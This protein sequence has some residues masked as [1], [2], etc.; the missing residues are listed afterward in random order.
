MC[1]IL[2]VLG[3]NEITDE[4]F[5]AA[6]DTMIARGPDDAGSFAEREVHLGFRR[7]S[8]IDLSAAGHQPMISADGRYVIVFNGEIYNFRALRSELEADGA[9]FR[10]ESDTEV[11]LEM[12][13]RQGA[14]TV[15]R[16]RGM[17]ALA[18][19]DRKE[20]DLFLAR[21]RMGIKPLYLWRFPGGVAFASE[22]RALRALPGGPSTINR[23][24]IREFLH[25]GSVPE[26]LTMFEG[27][28]PL[29]PATTLLWKAGVEKKEV[30]W[31]FPQGPPD[32]I[33]RG[34]AI[35]AV[36]ACLKEAV[37]LHCISD[38]PLGAF[39]SGGIDSSAIVSLMRE[40]G[41]EKISTF[42]MSFPQSELDEGP[43]AI[44]VAEELGTSHSNIS[45][46]EQLVKGELD[47]F[48]AAMDQP[49]C[50]GFNSYMVS[51]F[52]KQAGLTVSLSGIGGD[53]LFAGYP[54]FHRSERLV[55]ILSRLPGFLR[56]FASR[57]GSRFS[58]RL[59]KLE[60]LSIDRDPA[61]ATYRLLRGLFSPSQVDALLARPLLQIRNSKS[62]IRNRWRP[63]PLSSS[64]HN[65]DITETMMQLESRRY[66][67][68]QLLRDTD[69]FGMAHSLE[70]RPPFLDHELVEIMFRIDPERILE[71]SQ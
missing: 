65:G 69:V 25:W 46:T 29:G 17:F 67:L 66:M 48:F 22:I 31:D 54:T 58:Q 21:D 32:I 64:D 12:Y 14:A 7:L 13:A 1:G 59:R 3:R 8:I 2:G 55:P 43:Y 30:Y 28:E 52:A 47:D 70:I 35:D 63:L 4:Q 26:P 49:T 44:R 62:E 23:Q 27:V 41:Q 11:I 24:A 45:V 6:R 42:S 51:K 38:A 68:N 39:L 20:E 10:S 18:I 34:D 36:R 53:E 61:L 50:D 19:Y 33:K 57:E 9:R 71:G 56:N 16:L 60:N 5:A 15:K 40:A 37:T